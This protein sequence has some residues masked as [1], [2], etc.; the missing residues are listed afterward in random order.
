MKKLTINYPGGSLLD[1]RKKYEKHFYT[2]KD[3]WY[4]QEAF[5]KENIPA[6]T[7]EIDFNLEGSFLKT[8]AE[9]IEG[10]R[11]QGGKEGVPA[12]VLVYALCSHYEETGDCLLETVYSRTSSCDSGGGHVVVGI[13]DARGLVVGD[14]W[15]DIRSSYVGLSAARKLSLDDGELEALESLGLEARVA[16]LEAV[17]K[18]HNLG[19]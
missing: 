1:I 17:I 4:E 16:K 11:W 13:F 6:G 14:G 2:K 3:A 15:D 5:A 19:L 8:W 18:H 12:A 10:G 9:Q 7:W